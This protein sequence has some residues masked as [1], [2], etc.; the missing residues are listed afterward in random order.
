M[1]SLIRFLNPF[2][3]FFSASLTHSDVGPSPI[4][5]PLMK[6][7]I[8]PIEPLPECEQL[9]PPNTL[10]RTAE[11]D[12]EPPDSK[13]KVI[14]ELE[15]MAITGGNPLKSNRASLPPSRAR[16]KNAVNGYYK[17]NAYSET[18]TMDNIRDQLERLHIRDPIIARTP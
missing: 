14:M 5:L 9:T 11:R 7:V 15:R 13:H 8:I 12:D 2:T 3:C 6:H 18:S 16:N 1:W 10:N 4:H 17:N